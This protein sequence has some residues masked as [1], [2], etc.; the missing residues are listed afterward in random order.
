MSDVSGYVVYPIQTENRNTLWQGAPTASGE[1]IFV[2]AGGFVFLVPHGFVMLD[3]DGN[4][5]KLGSTIIIQSVPGF[6]INEK[7]LKADGLA[8]VVY[9]Y[10]A[11]L[12]KAKVTDMSMASGLIGV[13]VYAGIS[14]PANVPVGSV[15]IDDCL[16]AL[17]NDSSCAVKLSVSP[18]AS[19]T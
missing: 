18:V 6:Q 9:R 12:T 7:H 14:N 1:G 3:E 11:V 15:V 13:P 16:C 2:T 10:H 8:P 5:V 19:I 17:S 4:P